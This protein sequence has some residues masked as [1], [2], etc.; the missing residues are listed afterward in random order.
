ML[1]NI[2]HIPENDISLIKTKLRSTYEKY[3]N[4]YVLYEYRRFVENL[5]KNDSIVLMRQDRGG[6]V[7]IVDKHK[8]TEKCLAMLNTKQFSKIHVDPTKKTEAK[9][10]RLLPKIKSKLTIQEY[11]P[12]HPT[13]SCQENF[14][15]PLRYTN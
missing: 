9:I 7:A 14:M 3:S 1:K 12:L 2:S 10:Q 13:G 4:V 5:S 15:V 6:D 8:Y 11:H